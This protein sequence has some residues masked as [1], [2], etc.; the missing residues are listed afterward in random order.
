MRRIW[1]FIVV[2]LIMQC[3][4]F[5]WKIMPMSQEDLARCGENRWAITLVTS[6]LCGIAGV[7]IAKED[8]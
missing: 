2:F 8:E 4:A 5:T 3:V 1:L 6:A 7:L